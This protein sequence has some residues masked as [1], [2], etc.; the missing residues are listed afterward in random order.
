MD[1]LL[2]LSLHSLVDASVCP[3]RGLNRNLGV[4]WQPEPTE[5]PGQG[6]AFDFRFLVSRLWE[7]LITV[8][9]ILLTVPV[10]HFP[11][12]WNRANKS[13]L[14]HAFVKIKLWNA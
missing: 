1:L 7:K 9:L 5:L 3:D 10:Y 13:L 12:P 2:H 4:L 8:V 14:R 6:P 11:H